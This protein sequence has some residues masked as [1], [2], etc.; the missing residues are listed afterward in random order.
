MSSGPVSCFAAAGAACGAIVTAS[1]AALLPDGWATGVP[2]AIVT[3][4]SNVVGTAAAPGWAWY[5]V[6]VPGM[7]VRASSGGGTATV[8]T[9][10]ATAVRTLRRTAAVGTMVSASSSPVAG[11]PT[12]MVG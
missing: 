1:A 2:G 3:A 12:K 10:V 5:G 9:G 4:S 11:E 8:G 7:I 6:P